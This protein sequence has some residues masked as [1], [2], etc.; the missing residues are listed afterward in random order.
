MIKDYYTK[1]LGAGTLAEDGYLEFKGSYK[2][3][4]YT[5][6]MQKL[7]YED[8]PGLML[9]VVHLGKIDKKVVHF[10]IKCC[11]FIW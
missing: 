4:K 1:K 2:S 3:Y 11:I 5:V 9:P 7:D 6:A 8:S 10:N